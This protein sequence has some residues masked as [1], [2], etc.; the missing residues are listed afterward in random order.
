MAIANCSRSPCRR[1]GFH[2]LCRCACPCRPIRPPAAKPIQRG[3]FLMAFVVV[4]C[5]RAMAQHHNA[6]TIRTI[7]FFISR[8]F[9]LRKI[10]PRDAGFIKCA[11]WRFGKNVIARP[12]GHWQ[13][14][15]PCYK[16][17]QGDLQ[18]V[19]QGVRREP[20][21]TST[22]PVGPAPAHV[23]HFRPRASHLLALQWASVISI[24]Q[25][26][27]FPGNTCSYSSASCF[28]PF[29]GTKWDMH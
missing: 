16:P 17:S 1:R 7:L 29:S 4:L 8:T 10:C 19:S 25:R 15:R 5:L 28:L 13:D 24:D 21:L 22:Y 2:A 12:H 18:T 27:I 3:V 9:V 20:A 26:R 6:R 14:R 23:R 11:K